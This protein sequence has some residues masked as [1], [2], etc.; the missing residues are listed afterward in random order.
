MH[1]A[2]R[3]PIRPHARR[4]AGP[5]VGARRF[6]ALGALLPALHGAAQTAP[7]PLDPPPAREPAPVAPDARAAPVP[8]RPNLPGVDDAQ[9]PGAA[10]ALMPE[11]SF[12]AA[13]R[14]RIGPWRDSWMFVFDSDED[15][16]SDPPI[17]L[18]PCLNL[19]EMRRLAESRAQGATFEVSGEV[20]VY[21]GRNYLLPLFFTT[22]SHGAQQP[23]QRP[24]PDPDAPA[25]TPDPDN[26]TAED[27][28]ESL[29]RDEAARP[30]ARPGQGGAG[31][32]DRAAPRREGEFLRERRG[33]LW[34]EREGRWRFVF[35]S[36]A[37]QQAG[38]DPPMT[39]LPSLALESM[40]RIMQR[41]GEA[42]SLIVSGR[43][44]VYEGENYLLPTMFLL[45]PDST[46]GVAS[47]H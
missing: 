27:I 23:A 41:R 1:D 44:F 13:R 8:A 39:V 5:F 4:A 18:L 17:T 38:V 3:N 37:S 6:A 34:R 28:I 40:E 26:P 22:V 15:G 46:D 35:D 21:H 14:G 29:K 19:L 25:R 16:R 32:A 36:G 43:V 47:A 31:H 20:F 2:A 45:A 11:G 9:L 42:T 7:D 33:R 10:G 12:V 24:A 30:A